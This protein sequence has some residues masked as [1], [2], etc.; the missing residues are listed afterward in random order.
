ML[1]MLVI[2][3]PDQNVSYCARGLI[4]SRTRRRTTENELHHSNQARKVS[5]RKHRLGENTMTSIFHFPVSQTTQ[6]LVLSISAQE[7]WLL[8]RD[9]SR[10]KLK[11]ATAFLILNISDFTESGVE[12]AQPVQEFLILQHSI[13]Y[14]LCLVNIYDSYH[15]FL[16]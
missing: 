10:E 14:S 11:S 12:I 1:E 4:T 7:S 13:R 3:I 6:I 5:A 9:S 16:K 15:H 2:S 8:A